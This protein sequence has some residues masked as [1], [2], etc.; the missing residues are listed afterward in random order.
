MIQRYT[1]LVT[2]L[3][4]VI[5]LSFSSVNA[6]SPFTAIGNLEMEVMDAINDIIDALNIVIFTQIFE[7]AEQDGMQIDILNLQGNQTVIFSSLSNINSDITSLEGNQT[8]IFSSISST[9]IGLTAQN[10]LID[11]NQDDISQLQTSVAILQNQTATILKFSN[12]ANVGIP[13]G[14]I[15][16]E[17]A[18]V[19]GTITKLIYSF[20]FISDAQ[21]FPLT[22][23]VLVN[24]VQ[25]SLGCQ[26]TGIFNVLVTCTET[27]SI[28][29]NAFDIISVGEFQDVFNQASGAGFASVFITPDP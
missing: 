8:I 14:L 18:G 11:I 24:G 19:D 21:S 7:Q 29:V 3:A 25:T 9:V 28:P 17:M 27:A 2:V 6:I 23:T 20:K 22:V 5:G 10:T 4:F 15:P 13:R 16:V 12:P 1:I 26:I